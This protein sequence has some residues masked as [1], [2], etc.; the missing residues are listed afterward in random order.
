MTSGDSPDRTELTFPGGGEMSRRMRAF[1]WAH[2]PVGDPRDWPA[3]LSTAVRI[4]LTSRFPMI[5]WWGKPLFMFYN[6]AFMPLMGS[7]HPA[8]MQPAEQV[9]GEIWPTVGPMLNSVLDTGEATFAEDLPLAMERHGY[10]EETHWNYSYS[11]LQDDDGNVRGVFTAVNDTTEQVVGRRRLAALQDLGAQAGQARSVSEACDLVV[12]SLERASHDVPFA[13]VYLRQPDGAVVLASSTAAGVPDGWPVAEVAAG[14][15]PV[16]V[17]DVVARFGELPSGGWERPPAEAMVLPLTGGTGG[18]IVLAASA[19]RALDSA[20]RSFLELVA[21][22]SAALINRAVAYEAQSRRAEELAELDRDKTAFFSNVSHEFR[23]PLTL[24]MG[25]VEDLRARLGPD[26]PAAGELDVIYRNSMRLGKLVNTLLDFSRTEAGRVQASFEP[27]DLGTFTAELASLFRS[28]FE[29]AGIAYQV[30]CPPL[31]EPVYV[32]RE[33][34]EKVV[35]NLLSN[36]LKFTFSGTVGV[37]LRSENERAVLRVADTGVGVAAVELPR[38]FDRFHRIEGG[39]SRSNEGSG[40][41]LA[42]VRELVGLH[43]GTIDVQSAERAGTTFTVQIPFGHGHLPSGSVS[44]GNGSAATSGLVRDVG[45]SNP[46]LLEAMHWLPGDSGPEPASETAQTVAGG[47]YD[48]D[49]KPAPAQ[50][51]LADDNADMRE[52]LQRLLQPGYEVTTVIDGQ[53]ALEAARANPPDIMISDVMMPRLGGLSLVAALRA[54]VRTAEVPVLLL[55]ARAGQEAAIEGLEAGADDYLVKP[56]SAAE[57][58]A[59]VRATV[60]LARQRHH[61]ARWR[62]AL[63]DSLHEAFYV[64]DA[65]GFIVEVNAGF[66]EIAGFGPDELPYP[67]MRPWW[68]DEQED[69]D[70][71]EMVRD[72][73]GRLMTDHSG[74]FTVPLRRRDGRRIW[75]T[76]NFNELRNPDNGR[77]MVVGTFRDVTAEHY[78]VQ[79]EAALAAMG[80][81]VSRGGNS[82]E[83]LRE[84]LAELRRLWR[85]REVTAATWMGSDPVTV[86]STGAFGSWESLP[87]EL[88]ER[89]SGLRNQPVLM[90][91]GHGV[92]DG[93]VAGGAVAG[94]AVAGGAGIRLEH[95]AGTLG[96]WIDLGPGRALGTEDRTLLSLVGGYLGQALYRA[97]QTDQQR[98]TALALQRAILGP[99]RLPAGFAVRYEPATRPLE[100]GGDW[101]DIVELPDGR[102]GIMVGD[103]VGHDLGA[104]TVMGQLRSACRALLL[105]DASVSQA[106]TAMDRFAAIVPGAECATVFC[107]ILD[108]ASGELRYSSAAHPPGIVVHPDGEIALLE[109]ARSLPLAI[110]PG[111]LRSEASYVLP[112]RSTLLLYTDGLVERRR[113]PLTDGIAAAGAAIRDFD[114]SSVEELASKIMTS[115]SPAGGYEDDVALVLYHHPAPLDMS[116][117][118]ESEQLASVRSRLRSWLQACDVGVSMAQDVL[119]AAGE[120][121][122][123]AIEHGHRSSPGELVRLRA[124]STAD[125]VRLTVSDRG[126]WRATPPGDRSLRGHGLALMRAL[127]Q[128]VTIEPGPTGT[129]VDMYI[130]IGGAPNGHSA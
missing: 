31:D 49:G 123:N 125:Q 118:A 114:G 111:G 94:G 103:C 86:T 15:G 91:V 28:A 73:L 90:P 42:L 92:A 87:D 72:A 52:Y 122:A 56:F 89:L 17:T 81:I 109:E 60:E 30:D 48:P 128:Q 12:R 119:V 104:A 71:R 101:Y 61:H 99:S 130:R 98:E 102:I 40:I 124:V 24:I 106:L 10:W 93:A 33:M 34:W 22:Q 83:V 44:A 4:C 41:G 3:T 76:G 16:T 107:G 78:A 6:D 51:L 85:A 25:P 32:D 100:V 95:P 39:P 7:K 74:S 29:R 129:T 54:D 82:V 67:L 58:L 19:G 120:A 53:A 97:Y 108:P 79:R 121:I 96:I 116:F 68:P 113:H 26:D 84:A 59:R 105:Q 112:P 46:F 57:L 11:P 38:L 77:R 65:D 64:V 2:S 47:R 1:D 20:Y 80:L 13:A 27:L 75:V 69:P 23:T 126:R 18:A 110:K 62:T 37:S 63:L 36:A 35:F 115:L 66:T 5:V 50:V 117:T 8:L 14:R 88:R 43:G 70:R 45:G 55:S 21:Q 127:M 9:W